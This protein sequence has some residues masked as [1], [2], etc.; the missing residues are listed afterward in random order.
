MRVTDEWLGIR[1]WTGLEI[2][3]AKA[4]SSVGFN[5]I[6]SATIEGY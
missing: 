3:K 6:A 1:T 4:D 2:L 5:S